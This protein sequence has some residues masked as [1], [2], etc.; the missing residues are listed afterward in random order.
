MIYSVCTIILGR[1]K[2]PGYLELIIVLH[3]LS[4]SLTRSATQGQIYFYN[5]LH[6]LE[7]IKIRNIL[8]GSSSTNLIRVLHSL[9]C[10]L[11]HS[12]TMSVTQGVFLFKQRNCLPKYFFYV[13]VCLPKCLFYVSVCLFMFFF[14][15]F[16]PL[17]FASLYLS[18]FPYLLVKK[19]NL[20]V[21]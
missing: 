20:K 10:S 4:H 12:L 19:G 17:L 8:K 2:I 7:R 3:S 5:S 18:T 1:R 9:T 13:S 15:L 21:N 14:S 11:T 16:V 6:I